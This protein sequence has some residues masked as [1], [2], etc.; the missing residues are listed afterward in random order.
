[1]TQDMRRS[2]SLLL[3]LGMALA[4]PLGLAMWAQTAAAQSN[5]L[6]T[7]CLAYAHCDGGDTSC[8]PNCEARYFNVDPRRATC[9][10]QCKTALDQCQTAALTTCRGQK[11]CH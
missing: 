10:A 4:V 6:C 2:G 9:L 1:M 5:A 11:A 7:A 8:T 3:R